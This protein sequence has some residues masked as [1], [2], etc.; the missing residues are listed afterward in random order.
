MCQKYILG[1]SAINSFPQNLLWFHCMDFG[2]DIPHTMYLLNYSLL[3]RSKTAEAY[4]ATQSKEKS[5]DNLMITQ[6]EALSSTYKS[7]Y[8]L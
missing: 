1:F 5:K 8:V 4:I 7:C 3:Y 2:V 6:F